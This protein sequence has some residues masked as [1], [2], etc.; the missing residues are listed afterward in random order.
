MKICIC[1][2]GNLGHVVAGYLAAKREHEITMLTNR[3][4]KWSK[5]IQVIDLYG[6][7]F[8]GELASVSSSPAEAL[9]NVDI[10]L[11][12]LPGFALH[13]ELLKVRDYISPHTKV[14]A[15][16][17]S[18]G[19]FF[20]AFDILP[21]NITLFGFQ[22]VPFIG[23]TIEYGKSAELKGYKKELN[24]AIVRCSEE[25]KYDLREILSVLFKTPVNLLHS[26][27]EAALTNSN[28]L[29]HPARLYS[30]WKD[31]TPGIVY[32]KN[33][34]FYQEWTDEASEFL[35][36]MDEEFQK[37]LR[38]LP[39]R[40]GSIPSILEYYESYDAQSLTNKLRSI[41]AFAGISS[42]MIEL[43]ENSGYIPDFDSRY[44]TEDIP[45]GM[46]YIVDVAHQIGVKI[47]NI[48]CIYS[49]GVSCI[50]KYSR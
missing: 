12:C 1:G 4:E 42:P 26:Y 49:W 3:P 37:L 43:P 22:R 21:D 29:L 18:S 16:V 36:A 2:G 10:V 33:P 9:S 34:L 48:E 38:H 50:N 27:Y 5:N 30:L 17:S 32:T 6:K 31:W 7:V 47:P 41:L 23:R 35:I 46:R 45:Y 13:D 40:E 44:F 19:F 25:E 39:V 11:I 20:E 8:K 15:V 14:G 24:V 28:P